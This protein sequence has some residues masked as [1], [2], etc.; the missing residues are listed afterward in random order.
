MQHYSFANVA[1]FAKFYYDLLSTYDRNL[2]SVLLPPP[3]AASTLLV[4]AK[5]EIIHYKVYVNHRIFVVFTSTFAILDLCVQHIALYTRLT[6][7]VLY[8][9]AL[10]WQVLM[11]MDLRYISKIQIRPKINETIFK[12]FILN[13][14]FSVDPIQTSNSSISD[15]IQLSL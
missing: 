10:E 2:S 3:C 4:T 14:S 8:M 15:G 13:S 11:I 5:S 9:K 6:Q 1:I 7:A 12:L